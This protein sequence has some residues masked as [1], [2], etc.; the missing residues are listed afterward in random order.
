MALTWAERRRVG[1]SRRYRGCARN[2]GTRRQWLTRRFHPRRAI[3]HTLLR[4]LAATPRITRTDGGGYALVRHAGEASRAPQGFDYF[5]GEGDPVMHEVAPG[6]I[7]A[8]RA[9]A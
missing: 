9:A 6:H 2:V 5:A 8:M 1:A 4:L 3:H 7:V